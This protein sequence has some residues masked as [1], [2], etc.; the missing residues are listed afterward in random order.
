MKVADKY[1]LV[2]QSLRQR[3]AVPDVSGHR[4]HLL[5]LAEQFDTVAEAAP[6]E[7]WSDIESLS[8]S[9]GA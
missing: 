8:H 6:K 3:A 2:A 9:C 1:R 4:D 7:D 5:E